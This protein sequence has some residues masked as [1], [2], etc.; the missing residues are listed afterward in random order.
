MKTKDKQIS[1]RNT[2]AN[3][4]PPSDLRTARHRG[5]LGGR[6]LPVGLPLATSFLIEDPMRILVLSGALRA[7]DLSPVLIYTPKI[8]NRGPDKASASRASNVSR[9]TSLPFLI[10][11]E[12]IRNRRNPHRISSL[13]FSNRGSDKASASRANNV[14]R[15][16][17]LPFL[18]YTENIRNRRNPHRISSLNFSNLYNLPA[19]FVSDYAS[20]PRRSSCRDS[21]GG[22][23]FSPGVPPSSSTGVLTPEA[24]GS[25]SLLRCLPASLPPIS[26]PQAKSKRTLI[27]GNGINFSRKSLK[28]K[29][30][31]HA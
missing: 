29:D 17:S 9:G 15:G 6:S 13:N 1:N 31:V 18:I 14:S 24:K 5:L 12:N 22:R 27:Y 25:R 8:R 10:Y 16:T 21:S 20:A 28:T 19:L 7:K 30:R 11:T 26:E 4:A 3:A 2:I 23:G